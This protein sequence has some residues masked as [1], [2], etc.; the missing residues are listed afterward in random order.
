MRSRTGGNLPDAEISDLVASRWGRGLAAVEVFA[1]R[2][3]VAMV[4]I[5]GQNCPASLGTSSRLAT[6]PGRAASQSPALRGRPVRPVQLPWALRPAGAVRP[7]SSWLRPLQ[8]QR[9]FHRR[10]REMLAKLPHCGHLDLLPCERSF[11]RP[12]QTQ[13][14]K[15]L[16]TYRRPLVAVLRS[17]GRT[18]FLRASIV[19]Q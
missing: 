18:I 7:V 14:R 9:Q 8:L 16:R 10:H 4:A 3:L 17:S 11:T 13:R 15:P 19:R 12:E 2:F 1:L 6:P 5:I